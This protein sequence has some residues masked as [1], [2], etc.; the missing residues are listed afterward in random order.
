M[1]GCMPAGEW[2]QPWPP[3]LPLTLQPSAPCSCAPPPHHPQVH[4]AKLRSFD[5][6]E[7]REAGRYSS[8]CLA[9]HVV[10]DGESAWEVCNHMGISMHELRK[11][12]KGEVKGLQ[13]SGKE[14]GWGA[15]RG[16]CRLENSGLKGGKLPV[17]NLQ[18]ELDRLASAVLQAG[19]KRGAA[20]L[21]V[22]IEHATGVTLVSM[23]P[24]LLIPHNL[25]TS[26]S[27]LRCQRGQAGGWSEA[28][29]A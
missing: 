3:T 19:E 11:L 10:A 17:A 14:S 13:G 21:Q 20:R 9:E 12:N 1:A 26:A 16:G 5:R 25:F 2:K 8:K 22:Q 18:C 27:Y 6:R 24:G 28:G 4:K 15:R 29:G 7:L 23:S